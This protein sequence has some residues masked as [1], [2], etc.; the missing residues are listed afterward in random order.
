MCDSFENEIWKAMEVFKHFLYSEDAG[1]WLNLLF[2][3]LLTF[4]SMTII[5]WV[6]GIE[7]GVLPDWVS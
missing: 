1:F 5:S 6:F 7:V 2:I 3:A 4:A